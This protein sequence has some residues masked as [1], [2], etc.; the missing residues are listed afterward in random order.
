MSPYQTVKILC[1]LREK[2]SS[3]EEIVRA[4]RFHSVEEMRGQ[5]KVWALPSWLAGE[6]SE[7]SPTSNKGRKKRSPRLRNYGPRKELPPASNAT[8]LFRE[9][10]EALLKSAELLK[11]MNERLL[12]KYFVR[13]NV[14][15]TPV[16]ISREHWPKE[17]WEAVCEQYGYD[18]EDKDLKGLLDP[19][20][21]TKSPGG[22]TKSPSEVLATLIGVYALADGR[23]DLLV[24]ALHR[25]AS[26]VTPETWEEI[27]QCVE[28]SRADKD[29]RD[30]LK[31]VARQLATWVRGGEV[32]PGK[33]ARLSEMDHGAARRIGHYRKQGLTNEEISE[34]LSHPL[35]PYRKE[36]GTSYTPEDVAELGD[37]DL[38]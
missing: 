33:P 30:G 26:S 28:G 37:L 23:M 7:T 5:F 34:R 21:H 1:D 11:H 24:D 35:L 2:R 17:V 13:E 29:K 10:L 32:A 4:L 14:G 19:N 22:V 38:S 8:E 9:R 36:D 27:R 31:I 16:W 15:T 18:P 25:D 12:G 20:V 3:D 6:E